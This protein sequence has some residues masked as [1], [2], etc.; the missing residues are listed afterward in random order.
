M[1]VKTTLASVLM[2]ATFVV[3]VPLASAG[4][5][6]VPITDLKLIEER[7]EPTSHVTH[8]FHEEWRRRERHRRERHRREHHRHREFHPHPHNESVKYPTPQID[9]NG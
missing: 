5:S 4:T 6:S 9:V 2:G 7:V 8:R 3:G 1:N